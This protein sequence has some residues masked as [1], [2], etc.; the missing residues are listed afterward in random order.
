MAKE[1]FIRNRI[2]SVGFAARGAW[3]LIRTESS[4]QVQVGISILV[5]AAGFYFN[6]S[7]TE[8]IFQFLAIGVVMGVEGVNT[9]VEKLSDYIQPEQDPFIGMVKDISAGAVLMTSI[10]ASIV[11]FIIYFPKI[12]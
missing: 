11:G 9:A 4:I 2:K 12:F 3:Y 7:T 1:S 10:A 8:W 5:T 6:I